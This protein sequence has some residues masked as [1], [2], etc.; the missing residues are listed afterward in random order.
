MSIIIANLDPG[1]S[2]W[3]NELL[4]RRMTA[5]RFP[6]GL[7]IIAACLNKASRQ[8]EVYDSYVNGTTEGFLRAIED[9][10][11]GIVL[12][13]GFLGNFGYAFVK[14]IAFKIK[15]ISPSTLIIIGG[16]MATTIPELL[17][18]KT[19]ID[20]VVKGEGENTIIELVNAIEKRSDLPL[21]KGIY[22]KDSSGKVVF[23]GERERI[24][25]LDL[26]PFP[27]Y[28]VFP[29]KMY[30][31]YLKDTGRC[32]DISAS[33]GCY[34]RCRFCKLMFGQGIASYS[35]KSVVEH[36]TYVSERYWPRK[37]KWRFQGRADRISPEMVEKMLEVG[38][39]DI[40]FG[41]ESGSQEMLNR[42]AKNLDIKKALDNLVVI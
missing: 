37:F 21:V 20:F 41:I 22:F 31:N 18:S 26:Y 30:V 7:G 12:L 42:Y 8:F 16:P 34:N 4:R 17:V 40:S 6:I 33:R 9:M 2:H 29:I 10:K 19:P 23:T 25:N 38:L 35:C 5:L 13:S 14:D 3:T 36:M 32:W 1:R 27:L 24:K 39:F 15:T 11:P 28:A